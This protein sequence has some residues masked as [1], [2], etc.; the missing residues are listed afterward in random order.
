MKLLVHFR[1]FR[2]KAEVLVGSNNSG[3]LI[4]TLADKQ[5]KEQNRSQI[6]KLLVSHKILSDHNFL[7][8]CA[9]TVFISPTREKKFYIAGSPHIACGFFD[10]DLNLYPEAFQSKIMKGYP[11]NAADAKLNERILVKQ[12]FQLGAHYH[13]ESGTNNHFFQ[14][15][16][17][18]ASSNSALF[19]GKVESPI[20]NAAGSF[21]LLALKHPPCFSIFKQKV[22]L[23]K[24]TSTNY[25]R[26][27]DSC[28]HAVLSS[29]DIKISNRYG[30]DTQTALALIIKHYSLN[31]PITLADCLKSPIE[32]GDA[33]SKRIQSVKSA[34]KDTEF[35]NH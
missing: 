28:A 22:T 16:N 35:Q 13:T 4:Q 1:G 27:N 23:Y 24:Q 25:D 26:M 21:Y 17:N 9:T 34:V 7:V 6:R 31:E 18:V 32:L 10:R 15:A 2:T 5:I 8:A 11:F 30:L 12:N 14:L 3:L 33:E 29:L 20:V 19:N